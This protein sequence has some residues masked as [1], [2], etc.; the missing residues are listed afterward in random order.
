M[1]LSW[2]M[3]HQNSPNGMNFTILF[4]PRQAQWQ[5]HYIISQCFTKCWV[6]PLEVWRPDHFAVCPRHSKL[7]VSSSNT[8]RGTITMSFPSKKTSR[9]AWEQVLWRLN[10]WQG[11]WKS[12][13]L[14]QNEKHVAILETINLIHVSSLLVWPRVDMNY[15]YN[16]L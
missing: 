12:K 16:L 1:G 15:K 5:F 7:E 6:L 2:Q 3:I 4:C 14:V 8:E 9:V 11:L 10:Q 13:I